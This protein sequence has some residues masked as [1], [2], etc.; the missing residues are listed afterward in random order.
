[1][2]AKTKELPRFTSLTD[3]ANQFAQADDVSINFAQHAAHYA[4]DNGVSSGKISE[5][6]KAALNGG[7][8]LRYNAVNPAQHY[9]KTGEDTYVPLEAAR[10]GSILIGVE[11]VMSYTQHE[12]SQLAKSRPV[13][14]GIAGEWRTA[15]TKYASKKRERLT[16]AIAA[17]ERVNA[18]LPAKKPRAPNADFVVWVKDILNE[19]KTKNK[20]ARS[21]GDATVVDD[22]KL[23]EAI[24]AFRVALL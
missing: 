7:F 20:T 3:M 22:A 21:R 19:I 1:M 12:F 11:V 16:K 9:S 5:E 8:M 15:F 17:I 2:K 18:G 10:D 4:M 14:H 23:N 6:H 13:F 24:E